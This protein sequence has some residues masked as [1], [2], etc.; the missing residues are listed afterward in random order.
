MTTFRGYIKGLIRQHG[1]AGAVANMIGMSLSAFSRGVRNEGTLSELNLLRLSKAVGESPDTVLRLA[2]KD[3]V[4]DLIR[5]QY[6]EPR[7]PLSDE[8]RA[9]LALHPAIKRHLLRLVEGLTAKRR[10][11]N[12]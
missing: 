3:E 8:D 9:L 12:A 11:R 5:D 2:D 4:A 7:E 6:G 10:A 1:T